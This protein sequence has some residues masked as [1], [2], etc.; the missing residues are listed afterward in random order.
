[1]RLKKINFIDLDYLFILISIAGAHVNTSRFEYLFKD[2]VKQILQLQP[3]IPFVD[4]DAWSA[5]P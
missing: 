2:G 5:N 3:L 1:L 4:E